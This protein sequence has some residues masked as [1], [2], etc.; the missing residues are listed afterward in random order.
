[1]ELFEGN[2]NVNLR[3]ERA[4]WVIEKTDI[5]GVG[6]DRENAERI[7][8][9][10]KMTLVSPTSCPPESHRRTRFVSNRCC[11]AL[12]LYLLRVGELTADRPCGCLNAAYCGMCGV[13]DDLFQRHH[14]GGKRASEV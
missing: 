13:I 2:T 10:P 4:L 8:L 9:E 14:P 12:N 5:A 6:I 1:M 7:V 11:D 3:L